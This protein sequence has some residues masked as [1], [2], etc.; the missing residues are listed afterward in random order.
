MDDAE[1]VPIDLGYQVASAPGAAAPSD[2]RT[3]VRDD[4]TVVI[5]ILAPQPCEPEPSTDDE[6]VVCAAGPAA[7]QASAPPSVP[8]PMEQLGAAL[9]AKI[10]PVELGSI[11]RGDGTRAFGLRIRF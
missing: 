4:G 6:I 1:R 3:S 7:E 11:D 2:P 9:N 10:G 5:D 8:S